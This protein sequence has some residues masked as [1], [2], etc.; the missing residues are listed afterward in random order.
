MQELPLF[1][2]SI[3]GSWENFIEFWELMGKPPI[4]FDKL[5]YEDINEL[6]KDYCIVNIPIKVNNAGGWIDMTHTNISIGRY[7]VTELTTELVYISY[8]PDDDEYESNESIPYDEV[9]LN[10]LMEI[11]NYLA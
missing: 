6:K 3:Y 4:K 11:Y 10:V 7:Y 1:D 5:L 9:S 2:I 8:Y